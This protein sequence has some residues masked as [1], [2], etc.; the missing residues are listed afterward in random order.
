MNYEWPGNIR[1]LENVIERARRLGTTAMVLP[2]D[3]PEMIVEAEHHTS[4]A[5]D[6]VSRSDEGSE[7]TTHP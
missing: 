7:K 2:E 6:E 3:L 5:R 4:A 1:E